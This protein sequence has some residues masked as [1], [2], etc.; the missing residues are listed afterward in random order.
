MLLASGSPRRAELLSQLGLRFSVAAVDIDE[1]P[2]ANEIAVDYV[3]RMSSEKASEAMHRLGKMSDELVIL[4]A[5]TSVIVD[6]LILGKP[7]DFDQFA[8]MMRSLS[9]KAH[10]VYTAVS[11]R[12][13]TSAQNILSESSVQF[14][15][16]GES[17]ITWYWQSGEPVDKA[18]GYAIQGLG[19]RFVCSITGSY[20]GI[21][22]LPLYETAELLKNFG[23]LTNTESGR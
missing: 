13:N 9:G 10:R 22:G 1:T 3:Q 8:W 4:A 18:G 19:A 6:D 2:R 5:D 14:A 17:D 11:V 23:I 21:V 16:I 20:S 15:P 7:K 12:S